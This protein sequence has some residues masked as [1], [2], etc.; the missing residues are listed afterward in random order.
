MPYALRGFYP[1]IPEG[2]KK[3]VMTKGEGLVFRNSSFFLALRKA[4]LI[5][6]CIYPS[7][8]TVSVISAKK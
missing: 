1:T 3:L 6:K 7:P 5:V 4:M 8:R 2:K